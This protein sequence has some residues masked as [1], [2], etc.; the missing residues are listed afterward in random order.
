MP[1]FASR[2]PPVTVAVG[3]L[4][5][6]LRGPPFLWATRFR[7]PGGVGSVL[8]SCIPPTAP[9][10]DGAGGGVC[11]RSPSVKR[12]FP[13]IL[14]YARGVSGELSRPAFTKL[15]LRPTWYG[16]LARAAWPPILQ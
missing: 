5:W 15:R 8:A 4:I 12:K 3:P 9:R 14:F 6:L 13:L 10:T 16:P 11:S 2:A 7:T 1:G